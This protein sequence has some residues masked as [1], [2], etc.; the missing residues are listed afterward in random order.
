MPLFKPESLRMEFVGGLALHMETYFLLCWWIFTEHPEVRFN[1][2]A[3]CQYCSRSRKS[4]WSL[5]QPLP[6]W[7][8]ARGRWVV[9]S[10]I[11]ATHHEYFWRGKFVAT[12]QGG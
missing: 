6:G 12:V 9:S 1:A 4:R 2:A 3:C 8:E 5:P 11:V 10:A 7:L